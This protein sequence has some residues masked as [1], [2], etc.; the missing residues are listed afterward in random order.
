MNIP[1]RYPAVRDLAWVMASPSLISAT[2]EHY[3]GAK[4]G[5]SWCRQVYAQHQAWLQALDAD[6]A[7]LLD[8]LGERRSPLLG[9]YFESLIGFWL[10]RMDG[11]EVLGQNRIVGDTVRQIGEFDFLFRHQG[12]VFHWEASVKFY[13]RYG[14]QFLGP[15]PKDSLARKLSKVFSH[16]LRLSESPLAK[17]C[18][19]DWIGTD[20]VKPQAFIK[21]YLFYPVDQGDEAGAEN[22]GAAGHLRGQWLRIQALDVFLSQKSTQQRW[23]VLDRLQWLAPVWRKDDEALM[24][25]AQLVQLLQRHFS[26]DFRALMVV[27]LK[28]DD[29][30]GWS[31][32]SRTMVVDDDWPQPGG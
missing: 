9:R 31:E 10:A 4:V 16:Q 11:V 12:Q 27:E 24:T 8:W 20:Q 18:L 17:R 23:C 15:N 22:G 14:A 1:F 21:G 19:Q 25:A 30:L 32:V 28:Q 26:E 7:A 6:P 3:A 13:L 2:D 29:E 5:D